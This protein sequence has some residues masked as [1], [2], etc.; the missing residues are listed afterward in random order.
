MI[1]R[2]LTQDLDKVIVVDLSKPAP[3]ALPVVRL[4][5]PGLEGVDAHPLY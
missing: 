3:F 1:D 2:M 5:I 4:V